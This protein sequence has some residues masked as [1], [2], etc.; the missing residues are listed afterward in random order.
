LQ[1]T[2]Q[3]LAACHLYELFGMKLLSSKPLTLWT[4]LLDASL[5]SRCYGMRWD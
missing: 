3:N 4:H 2:S 5:E 1:T